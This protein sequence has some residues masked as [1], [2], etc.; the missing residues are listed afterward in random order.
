MSGFETLVPVMYLGENENGN[1]FV[2]TILFQD[3]CPLSHFIAHFLGDGALRPY[4]A[5][6]RLSEPV[7]NVKITSTGLP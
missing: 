7:E 2:Q 5:A 1:G 6:V 3:S 4:L